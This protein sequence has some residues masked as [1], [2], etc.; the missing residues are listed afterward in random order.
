[1]IESTD[2]Q[3]TLEELIAE[4][5]A[6]ARAR[7]ETQVQQ[8]QE[9]FERE[10]NILPLRI[11]ALCLGLQ[12]TKLRSFIERLGQ[13][14]NLLDSL[15]GKSAGVLGLKPFVLDMRTSQVQKI[16]DYLSKCNRHDYKTQKILDYLSENYPTVE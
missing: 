2:P 3:K 7:T 6:S 13:L 9:E 12:D 5:V 16:R 1:M 15:L 4:M 10:I 14:E 11:E 8:R